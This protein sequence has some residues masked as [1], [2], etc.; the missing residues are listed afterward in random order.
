MEMNELLKKLQDVRKIGDAS[1]QCRCPTHTDKKAS[2]TVTEKEDKILI[3]CHAGCRTYDILNELG[4]KMSDLYKNGQPPETWETQIIRY[5]GKQLEDAYHYTDGSG[6]YLYTKLR[7]VGKDIQYGTLSKDKTFMRLGID[8]TKKTLFN[9]PNLLKSIEKGYPVYFVEGEKDVNTLKSMGIYSA[10][11]CGGVGDWRKDFSHYFKGAR[12]VILPDND[13][14]GFNLAKAVQQDIKNFAFSVKVVPTS[15]QDKGDVTDYL[16]KEGHTLEELKALINEVPATYASWVTLD[17][18][19][20]P[21]GINEGY[22]AEAVENTLDYVLVRNTAANEEDIYLYRNGV[23]RKSNRGEVKAEI[24]KYVPVGYQ[25]ENKCNS[26]YGLLLCGKHC[27]RFQE[28]DADENIINVKNGLLDICT[29][30][31]KPH[32]PDVLTSR[33]L[34]CRY[35]PNAKGVY[36]TRFFEDLCTNEGKIDH[37]QMAALQEWLGLILSNVAGYRV[38]KALCLYSPL[39]NTGKSL[40][41][42]LLTA[43]LGGD[44]TINIPIQKLSERFTM[45]DIFGKRLVAIGDQ[46]GDAVTDS[47]GFKQLTG[48]DAVRI[49]KKGKSGYNATFTGCMFMICNN[50]PSFT[51]DKGGHIFERLEIIKCRNVIPKEKRDPLL[52]DK[53]KEEKD[54]VFTWA[55]I[56]LQRLIKNHYHFTESIANEETLREY[57][58]HIDTLYGFVSEHCDITGDCRYDRINKQEFDKN[59]TAW[60]L[61]NELEPLRTK[62]ISRRAEANGIGIGKTGGYICYKGIRYKDT[63]PYYKGAKQQKIT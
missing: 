58:S 54:A 42:N 2:L 5:K 59:Y 60:C 7:F 63:S 17:K 48:G 10:T 16:K 46:S 6:N 15:K 4:L 23:Y 3:Y 43:I 57:R 33:Q 14:A 50:L 39:G 56:G 28:L 36:I 41:L 26:V 1:Y 12:V 21:K 49:E 11:T 9:L 19:G 32:T 24:K 30:E 55:M 25:T 22:L 27:K 18:N 52:L 37:A 62:N 13:E 44:N 45:A 47:S 8:K 40:L 20:N 53:L 51:D 38:K 35:D 29:M 61:E 34:N 31:L